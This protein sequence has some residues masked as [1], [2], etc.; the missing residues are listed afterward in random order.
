MLELCNIASDR[1]QFAVLAQ[2]DSSFEET[3]FA[4]DLQAVLHAS[5]NP[6]RQDLLE[7][8]AAILRNFPGHDLL[9]GPAEKLLGRNI[10]VARIVRMPVEIGSTLVHQEHH[11]RKSVENRAISGFGFSQSFC[12]FRSEEHTSELQS[13]SNLVCRLL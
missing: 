8:R 2:Y 9:H 7:R 5:R 3:G 12:S 13:Q 6:G 4:L 1:K 11:V 10:Q